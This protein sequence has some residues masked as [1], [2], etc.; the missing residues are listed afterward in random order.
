VIMGS[1]DRGRVQGKAFVL[2]AE[3]L[4]LLRGRPGGLITRQ[5]HSLRLGRGGADHR[6]RVVVV[7]ADA[8][9]VPAVPLGDGAEP[10]GEQL[11]EARNIVIVRGRQRLEREPAVSIGYE[12]PIG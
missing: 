3:R 4:V 5:R 9:P 2:G 11:G 12:Q 6:D 8:F 7:G 1:H 10:D